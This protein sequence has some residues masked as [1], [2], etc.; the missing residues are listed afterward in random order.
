M[1]ELI[2]RSGN[3]ARPVR[4]SLVTPTA[5]NFATTPATVSFYLDYP[6]INRTRAQ[7]TLTATNSSGVWT[8]TW[9]SSVAFQ[10]TVYVSMRTTGAPVI[11]MDT[12]FQLTANVANIDPTS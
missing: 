1:A 10:G 9:S 3:G 7:T 12:Q 5:F 8:A 6:A 2:I 4:G 11:E